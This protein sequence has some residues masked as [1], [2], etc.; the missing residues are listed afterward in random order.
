M[1][2]QDWGEEAGRRSKAS[3]RGVGR[4]WV[5]AKARGTRLVVVLGGSETLWELQKSSGR[6]RNALKTSKRL[7]EVQK[8]FGSFKKALG[9]SEKL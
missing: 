4:S 2:K 1:G 9:G 3:N 7:W 5:E 8:R 6:F